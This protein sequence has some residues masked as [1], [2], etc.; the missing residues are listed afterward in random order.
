MER[1]VVTVSVSLDIDKL[2]GRIVSP[3]AGHARPFMAKR[4]LFR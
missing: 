3:G 2:G 1:L 4:I